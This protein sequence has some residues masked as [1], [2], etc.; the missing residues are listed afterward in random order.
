MYVASAGLVAVS[1]T[2]ALLAGPL[3]EVTTRAGQDLI[4]RTGYIDAVLGPD[5]PGA[6]QPGVGR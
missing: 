5:A 2:I 4:G 1:V 3:S 6:G